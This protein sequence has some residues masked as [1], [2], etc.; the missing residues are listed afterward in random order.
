MYVQQEV[1]FS[2]L[3]HLLSGQSQGKNY[4]ITD[5]D[6]AIRIGS[7]LI[8]NF[9]SILH[10]SCESFTVKKLLEDLVKLKNIYQDENAFLNT[11]SVLN[12]QNF[13]QDPD[14]NVKNYT[15]NKKNELIKIDSGWAGSSLLIEDSE[16]PISLVNSIK[17]KYHTTQKKDLYREFNA[18]FI[19]VL[20]KIIKNYIQSLPLNKYSKR[21]LSSNISYALQN[22]SFL[23]NFL[24]LVLTSILEP[25][26]D[27]LQHLLDL[28]K[29]MIET[30]GGGRTFLFYYYPS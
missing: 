7:L 24:E 9:E 4:V 15:I 19:P 26:K 5:G 30:N 2:N 28:Q 27:D 25:H 13:I 8:D 12:A 18:L 3:Q 14:L 20:S 17:E 23:Q 22:K 29:E 21:I 1:F 6:K 10:T 16:N 11:L